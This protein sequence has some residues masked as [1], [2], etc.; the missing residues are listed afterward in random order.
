MKVALQSLGSFCPALVLALA[1]GHVAVGTPAAAQTLERSNPAGMSTPRTYSH[2]VKVGKLLFIAGQVG[3][4]VQGKLVAPDMKAQLERALENMKIALA[5]QGADFSHVAKVTFYV[6]SID[7]FR[8]PGMQDI[9]TK[10]F[11][12]SKPA[13]TLAQVVRLADPDIK[14]EIEAIAALP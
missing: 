1:L 8:G 4:D 5:S 3:Y 2:V 9:R 6:T 14:I 7:D 11:G 10:Y 12:E 13:S